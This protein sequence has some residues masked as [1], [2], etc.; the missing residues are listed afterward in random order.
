MKNSYE[1]QTIERKI[2]FFDFIVQLAI[3][4][5][6]FPRNFVF[7][8]Y[9]DGCNIIYFCTTHTR[10]FAM[11]IIRKIHMMRS[12]YVILLFTALEACHDICYNFICIYMHHCI[13][14]Q[15]KN[16][17]TRVLIGLYTFVLYGSYGLFYCLKHILVYVVCD[18]K[19]PRV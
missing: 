5:S 17:I 19:Y 4:I 12:T 10:T 18:E 3:F 7:L 14:F 11:I 1:T 16:N 9:F 15:L 8:D 2:S 6:L 13:L